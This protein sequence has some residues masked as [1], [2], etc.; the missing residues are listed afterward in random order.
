VV[1]GNC[2]VEEDLRRLSIKRNNN[3]VS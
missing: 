1:S 3:P 2:Y